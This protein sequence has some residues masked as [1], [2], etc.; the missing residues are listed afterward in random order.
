MSFYDKNKQV[1]TPRSYTKKEKEYTNRITYESFWEHSHPFWEF[2]LITKGSVIHYLNGVPCK[3]S[4]GDLVLIRPGDL[5]Y[6]KNISENY[7]HRDVYVNSYSFKPFCDSISPSLYKVLHSTTGL[8][9]VKISTKQTSF[10]KSMLD[11]LFYAQDNENSDYINTLH[12]PVSILLISL[13]A[14]KYYTVQDEATR[15]FN[16]FLMKMNTVKYICATMEEVVELSGYSHGYLCKIFK[17]RTGKTLKNYHTELKI[18][19]SIELLKNHNLSIL[20]ISSI[21]GYDSLSHFIKLFKSYTSLTPKQY[22]QKY[23]ANK[24]QN[25]LD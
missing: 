23:F 25:V 20:K 24:K 9:C 21:L 4:E 18:N 10:V 6:F 8:I 3:L 5:H 14:K 13:I 15:E 22:R 16:D 7:E 1:Y 19:Y 11:E 17:E 2:F 12:V